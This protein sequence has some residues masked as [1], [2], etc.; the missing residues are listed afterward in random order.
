MPVVP[1]MDSPPTMPSRYSFRAE[2]PPLP[3]GTYRVYTDIV[4]ESG[5]ERTLVDS[6]LLKAWVPPSAAK[7]LDA[8]ESWSINE[9]VEVQPTMENEPHGEGFFMRYVGTWPVYAG[10]PGV[11]R[12]YLSDEHN[13][14]VLVEPYLGMT[15]HAVVYR[16]DGK[17]FMHLHPSGTASMAAQMAFGLRNRGDTAA[18]GRLVLDSTGSMATMAR[19]DSL[20]YLAFPYAFPSAGRYRVYVQVRVKGEVHTTAYDMAV[21]DSVPVAGPR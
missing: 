1:R 16:E 17:V 7:R 13:K 14:P 15:G 2:L 12:F 5:F 11:L 3:P 10:R 6:V 4:H 19:P 8:D 21:R 18:N 20:Y 9:R